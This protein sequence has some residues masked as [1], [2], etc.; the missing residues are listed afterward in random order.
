MSLFQILGLVLEIF[1]LVYVI[2]DLFMAA[3]NAKYERL[4]RFKKGTLVRIDPDITRAELCE[5]YVDFCKK[6]CCKVEF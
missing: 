5:Y 1:L 6:N 3:R 4:W 2:L